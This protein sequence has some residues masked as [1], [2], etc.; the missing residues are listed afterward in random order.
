MA[1]KRTLNEL[2]Q[3]KSFGY[4]QPTSHFKIVDNEPNLDVNYICELCKKFP[5]NYD[6]GN[7]VR[8]YYLHLK[9]N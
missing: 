5:N 9:N 8:K 4:R 2:R 1:K 3:S 7:E 6:L